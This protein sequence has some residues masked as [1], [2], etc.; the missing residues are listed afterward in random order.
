MKKHSTFQGVALFPGLA[1]LL[2]ALV[3]AACDTAAPKATPEAPA[4][5]E[6]L[7]LFSPRAAKGQEKLPVCH[8]DD[9]GFLHRIAVAEPAFDTHLAHGDATIG[10]DVPGMAG[11]VFDDA[12]APVVATCP[13]FNAADLD[14][15]TLDYDLTLFGEEVHG[16][17]RSIYIAG[18]ITQGSTIAE[19]AG[20]QE[21]AGTGFSCGLLDRN[22]EDESL[23]I[24][25]QGPDISAFEAESCRGLL[26]DEAE[27]REIPC[28]G[29]TCGEPF[30]P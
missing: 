10:G 26:Y 11:Y 27:D 17:V 9:E 13:C 22:F 5:G 4:L 1:C 6:A 25:V 15:F 19:F 23:S 28:E 3:L 20:V 2:V 7:S 12:C 30:T 21:I 14:A 8:L 18:A 24:F 16:D 29:D